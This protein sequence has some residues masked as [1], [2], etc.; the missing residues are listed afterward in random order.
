MYIEYEENK[1]EMRNEVTI[2]EYIIA[3]KWEELAELCAEKRRVLDDHL[4]WGLINLLF[5]HQVL[6]LLCVHFCCYN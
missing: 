5:Y 2:T 6:L 4:A 1:P 3:K